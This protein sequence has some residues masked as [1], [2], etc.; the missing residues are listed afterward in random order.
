ML[1]RS[2]LLFDWREML[3]RQLREQASCANATSRRRDLDPT[4]S[5][6]GQKDLKV[7]CQWLRL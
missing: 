6:L 4:V 7:P 3:H 2:F 5:V 1:G